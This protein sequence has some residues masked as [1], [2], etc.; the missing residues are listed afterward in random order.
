[1]VLRE[2]NRPLI[3]VRNRVQAIS[4]RRKRL[5]FHRDVVGERDGR[6]LVRASAPDLA[7]GNDFAPNFATADRRPVV[8]DGD[9]RQ[10]DSLRD[11]SPLAAARD[12]QL[13]RLGAVFELRVRASG[14]KTKSRQTCTKAQN[15]L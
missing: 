9:V 8:V 2:D 5:A 7:V 12:V 13:R 15:T 1:G 3:L 14:E 11:A 6:I 4:A 10:A